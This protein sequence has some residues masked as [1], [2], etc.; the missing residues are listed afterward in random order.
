MGPLLNDPDRTLF[1][2]YRVGDT[3]PTASRLFEDLAKAYGRKRVFLDHERLEGGTPWPERLEAEARRAS[4]MLVLVG[5]GWLRAHDPETFVRRLDQP[6]DWVRKEIETALDIGVLIVPLLVE[7][8]K[9]LS[10]LAFAT[11]PSLAP[12]AERQTLA[13]RRKEWPNDLGRLQELLQTHGFVRRGSQ[14][15]SQSSREREILAGEVISRA[16]AM[17]FVDIMRLIYVSSSKIAYQANAE[18]YQEFIEMAEQH[19]DE[20]KSL[21]LRFTSDIGTD[22]HRL[23][24]DIELQHSSMIRRLKRDP[25]LN[26][27]K[28]HYLDKMC[29]VARQIEEFSLNTCEIY[30]SQSAN[31]VRLMADEICHGHISHFKT[32]SLDHV[33]RVRLRIQSEIIKNENVF[34]GFGLRS[35][36]E[37]MVHKLAIPYFHVDFYLLK[38]MLSQ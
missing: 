18:R 15:H 2:N 19:F 22:L 16:M 7:E 14:A 3:G 32:F 37:D 26:A 38:R 1:I 30:Y 10:R 11:V 13:L 21:V 36:A 4:V 17:V 6:G 25:S 33:F 23:S 29:D 9:P 27:E 20:M 5:E 31:H 12:L 34:Y 24:C 28:I 35:I 8:A